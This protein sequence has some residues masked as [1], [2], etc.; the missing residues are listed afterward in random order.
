M[1]SLH[2]CVYNVAFRESLRASRDT[3]VFFTIV[4]YSLPNRRTTVRLPPVSAVTALTFSLV[5]AV[6]PVA[7]ITSIDNDDGQH[8]DHSVLVAI[9]VCTLFFMLLLSGF[10][11][12][13]CLRSS[14]SDRPTQNPKNT[15][16]IVRQPP[17]ILM[18]SIPLRTYY[19]REY[20]QRG[21]TRIS[22]V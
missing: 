7:D 16:T 21:G 1:D 9:I 20:P 19:P 13:W 8:L 10:T 15:T 17:I 18:P 2:R 22:V 4:F 14:E 11:L 3:Q 6:V 12:V 5:M